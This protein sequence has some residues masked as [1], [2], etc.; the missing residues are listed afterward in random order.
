MGD[1]DGDDSQLL[2]ATSGRGA[3]C[4]ASEVYGRK[5]VASVGDEGAVRCGDTVAGRGAMGRNIAAGIGAVDNW[6]ADTGALGTMAEA[7]KG[8][9]AS[10][11]HRGKRKSGVGSEEVGRSRLW[12]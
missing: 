4:T 12:S 3:K 7:G 9:A 11:G 5:A 2:L 6:G 10:C 1:G 8:A